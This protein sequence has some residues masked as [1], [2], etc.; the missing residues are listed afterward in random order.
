MVAAEGANG[1][2]ARGRRVCLRA[3]GLGP[4]ADSGQPGTPA[5]GHTAVERGEIS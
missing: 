1:S 2:R 5:C 4:C 3:P